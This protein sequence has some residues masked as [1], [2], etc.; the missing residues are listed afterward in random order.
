MSSIFDGIKIFAKNAKNPHFHD[1]VI[2]KKL[3]FKSKSYLLIKFIFNS[4]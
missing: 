2:T 3:F 1:D 4:F